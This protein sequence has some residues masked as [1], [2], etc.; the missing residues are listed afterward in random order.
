MNRIIVF[1]VFLVFLWFAVSFCKSDGQ[2][3]TTNSI[4]EHNK[5]SVS[6]LE[7]TFQSN[8][9]AVGQIQNCAAFGVYS[10]VKWSLVIVLIVLF[11]FILLFL[12]ISLMFSL[13]DAAE[14]GDMN[15]VK[16]ILKYFGLSVNTKVFSDLTGRTLLQ[17]AV[18][19]D[20]WDMVRWLVE[21]GA[22]VNDR[23]RYGNTALH[24]LAYDGSWEQV[25]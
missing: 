6:L 17:L 1:G 19:H 24:Y 25:L 23:S 12:R 5:S 21:R 9:G 22:R 8:I 3:L 4:D 16:D 15:R 18:Y 11:L 13:F 2:S 10:F 7:P 20:D 14:Q